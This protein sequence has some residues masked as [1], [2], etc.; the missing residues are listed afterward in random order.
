MAGEAL[1]R[2][3]LTLALLALGCDPA[4]CPDGFLRRHEDTACIPIATLD[5]G[6]DGGDEADTGPLDSGSDAGPCGMVCTGSTSVCDEVGGSCVQCTSANTTACIAPTDLCVGGSCAEC[7]GDTD[8]NDP[9]A[10]RCEAGTCVGCTASTQCAGITGTEVCDMVAETCVGCVTTADCDGAETCNLLAHTCTDTAVGDLNTCAACTNDEQCPTDHR[11]VPME[12]MGSARDPGYYCLL[13]AD[14]P[15]DCPNPFTV[16]ALI[17]R[18]SLNG[19]L[20]EGYCAID[21]DTTSC[22]AVRALLDDWRCDAGVDGRCF[23]PGE[24][25]MVVDVPGARC[26]D[27]PSGAVTNR[28]TYSCGGVSD[29]KPSGVGST[30][31]A[32]GTSEANYCGG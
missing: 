3:V 27:F 22:E 25:T 24:P 16:G 30:C 1:G 17:N 28:C 32:G 19:A 7:A 20:A 21:E 6:T 12:F 5:G 23:P 15:G 31:G 14:A 4:P 29:C 10:A 9:A 8:C 26:E 13:E 2:G 11:C 18:T